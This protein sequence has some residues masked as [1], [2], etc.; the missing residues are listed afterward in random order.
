M[1]PIADY[2]STVRAY[3]VDRRYTGRAG[4]YLLKAVAWEPFRQIERAM[5]AVRHEPKP[6]PTPPLFIL[7]YYRSGTT[8]LQ[9]T[10]MEDPR[11]GYMN[12]FH[13]FFS[14]AFTFTEPWLKPVFERIVRRI[15][16]LHPAHQIPFSFELPA[17]ED[18]SMIA[19]G[20]RLA[21]NWG[22]TY[23]RAFKEI[24]GRMSLM[25]GIRPE[26]REALKEHLLDLFW[27]VSKAN[28]HKPLIL[29]SPPQ[30]GRVSLLTEMFPDAKYVFI[31]R[32]PYDVFASNKKLWRSFG[33][34]W[35]QDIDD[36][37]VRE[38]ILWS[39]VES[40]RAYE[41]DRALIP[42]GNL[43][44]ISYEQFRASPLRVLR[45]VYETLS[46]GDFGA[47]EGR[48]SAYLA[49]THKSSQPPYDFSEVERREIR[50][51]LAPWIEGWGY[52]APGLSPGDR[53]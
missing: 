41:R 35:L 43:C 19:S 47:V 15:G 40:H 39:Y 50:A 53:I 44:E 2:I 32:N 3:G 8:H 18:V 1:N 4:L 6:L 12:F 25:K 17:E 38:Y 46:L 7:G 21:A 23:P 20:F 45:G 10:L 26:E 36:D 14:G 48:F 42:E 30:L 16:M 27:R 24:Y 9:E 5:M 51:R 29:K 52:E 28:D 37:T 31:R 49:D 22:Q 34:T 33:Q 11:F 13:C